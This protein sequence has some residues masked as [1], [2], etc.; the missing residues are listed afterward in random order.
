[1]AGVIAVG[2][3]HAVNQS[4]GLLGTDSRF[5][6]LVQK[7]GCATEQELLHSATGLFFL[8]SDMVFL[9]GGLCSAES[10][11]SWFLPDGTA[12]RQGTGQG[13]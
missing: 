10:V 7:S 12:S 9:H 13:A 3:W 1:M 6:Q 4:R 5:N 2:G 11:P 8:P